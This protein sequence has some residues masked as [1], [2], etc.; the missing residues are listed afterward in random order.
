MRPF[1]F[2][3]VD[4]VT[5]FTLEIRS[6]FIVC[7]R[8]AAVKYGNTYRIFFAQNAFKRVLQMCFDSLYI[9]RFTF[10][11]NHYN[12]QE[13]LPVPIFQMLN[14]SDA[15]QLT[16]CHNGQSIAQIL[17]FVHTVR[18][19]NDIFV[20]FLKVLYARPHE[21]TWR[22]IHTSGWFIQK[23]EWRMR[24]LFGMVDENWNFSLGFRFSHTDHC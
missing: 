19:Q 24:Y 20:M 10:R 22:W 18:R 16:I 14:R 15:F 6:F 13:S 2:G 1:A 17:A 11:M 4:D 8:F 12:Q 3:I 23:D 7:F 21:A 9:R 5:K